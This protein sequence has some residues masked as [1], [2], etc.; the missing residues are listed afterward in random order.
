M[1][2][3]RIYQFI[4]ARSGY[5]KVGFCS[6]LVWLVLLI[7]FVG[8]RKQSQPK[9]KIVKTWEPGQSMYD[10]RGL[11]RREYIVDGAKQTVFAFTDFLTE[12]EVFK[13]GIKKVH[14]EFGDQGLPLSDFEKGR[15]V[16]KAYSLIQFFDE[17]AQ[18][19]KYMILENGVQ[20][21]LESSGNE[22]NEGIWNDLWPRDGS[23]LGWET[24]QSWLPISRF[25]SENMPQWFY[26]MD[27]DDYLIEHGQGDMFGDKP[28]VSL[29]R[30]FGAPI[31]IE[32][33]E[34]QKEA[35][36]RP[37]IADKT[38]AMSSGSNLIHYANVVFYPNGQ[39]RFVVYFERLRI[40][41]DP[42]GKQPLLAV[43]ERTGKL[44]FIYQSVLQSEWGAEQQLV[45]VIWR[46]R[47]DAKSRLTD[48]AFADVYLDGDKV[49]AEKKAAILSKLPE[50]RQNWGKVLSEA[51][52]IMRQMEK[53]VP[54]I[55]RGQ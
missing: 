1:K 49:L 22:V 19:F 8:C 6:Y 39:P 53:H 15:F 46:K 29:S 41:L 50:P 23:L 11:Q 20:K 5:S 47:V 32:N 28:V 18:Q 43:D 4:Y 10:E 3:P 16:Q 30:A 35:A 36:G 24:I 21:Y 13:L 33:I 26:T 14:C 31:S 45:E 27:K 37:A 42:V 17:E 9:Q 54:L 44:A 52:E 51:L 2:K 55:R 40:Y 48:R 7:A 34:G 25:S 38:I 12:A